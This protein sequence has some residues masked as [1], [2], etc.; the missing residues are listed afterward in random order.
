MLRKILIIA[1]V[2][3]IISSCA[4]DDE[5]IR[6]EDIKNDFKSKIPGYWDNSDNVFGK[7]KKY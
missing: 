7:Y 1:F 4:N 3:T 6:G 2:S 5:V